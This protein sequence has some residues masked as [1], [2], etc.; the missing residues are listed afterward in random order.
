VIDGEL[1]LRAAPS[2]GAEVIAV[3]ADGAFVE[4][5]DGREEADGRRWVR[6]QS[7]RFGAGWSAEEFLVRA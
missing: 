5:I 6:V 3:L 7:S 4:I 1:N 2:G